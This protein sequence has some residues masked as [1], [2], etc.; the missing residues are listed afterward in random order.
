[1]LKVK[2]G[3]RLLG[4]QPPMLVALNA[5]KDAYDNLGVDCVI[6]SATDGN[7]S[8]GSW[9]HAGLAMDFRTRHLT[10]AQK[11]ALTGTVKKSLPEFDV[12]L[13]SSHLHVEYDP[14]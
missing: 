7:H 3:V 12:V 5:V 14:K 1:M 13:E 11:K 6:T 8:S 2:P 9:H 10:S 4:L